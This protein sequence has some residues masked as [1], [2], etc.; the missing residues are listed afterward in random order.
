MEKKL[1]TNRGSTIV[2]DDSLNRIINESP[3][4]HS[5]RTNAI[6][7]TSSE[8]LNSPSIVSFIFSYVY[9]EVLNNQ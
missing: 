6:L 5:K 1:V 9:N 7:E 8:T 2:L 3:A 4:P